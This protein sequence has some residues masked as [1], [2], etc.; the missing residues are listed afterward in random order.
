MKSF[1]SWNFW[2]SM[3]NGLENKMQYYIVSLLLDWKSDYFL[4]NLGCNLG[5]WREMSH[6]GNIA[7]LAGKF[8]HLKNWINIIFAAKLD[9]L[10]GFSSTVVSC[11]SI[12]WY[13]ISRYFWGSMLQRAKYSMLLVCVHSIYKAYLKPELCAIPSGG[14]YTLHMS[15]FLNATERFFF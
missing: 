6:L 7:F 11:R 5:I 12:A 1:S 8:K 3:K 10:R 2:S 14:M 13:F 4:S 15:S 9:N